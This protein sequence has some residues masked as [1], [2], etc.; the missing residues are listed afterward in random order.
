MIHVF[1]KNTF[2]YLASVGDRGQG[3]SEI[4]NM[5]SIIPDEANNSFYVFDHGHQLLYDYP[6]DSILSNP[7]Y[8]P[9]KKQT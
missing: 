9:Q 4:A 5:G 7:A 3:P 6:I 8:Q 2:A 1:D